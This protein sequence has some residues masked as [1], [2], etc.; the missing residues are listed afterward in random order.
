MDHRPFAW[1]SAKFIC[2]YIKYLE[3]GILPVN[4]L[5]ARE[6]VLSSDSYVLQE[7]ISFNILDARTANTRKHVEEVHVCLVVPD[8][9]T[10]GYVLRIYM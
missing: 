10:F 6:I 9:L 5:E 4:D 1:I 3:Q 2:P 8:Q 7:G